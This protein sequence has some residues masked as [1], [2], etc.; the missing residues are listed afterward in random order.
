VL[1]LVATSAAITSLSLVL[2]SDALAGAEEIVAQETAAELDHALSDMVARAR[3]HLASHQLLEQDYRRISYEILQGYSAMEG[4][5]LVQGRFVGHTSPTH[6]SAESTLRPPTD[7]RRTIREILEGTSVKGR[8]G[9]SFRDGND[10]VV[11]RVSTANGIN[12]WVMKRHV[13]FADPG[14]R[15][16]QAFALMLAAIALV[17]VLLVTLSAVR[18]RRGLQAI[19]HGLERMGRDSTYRLP[20]TRGELGPIADSVNRMADSRLRL[21]EELRREDRLRAMGRV[22]AG[23]AH[24][25]KNPLNSIRLCLQMLARARKAPHSDEE[26]IQMALGEVDR[27]NR[28]LDSLLLF[29]E[30]KPANLLPCPVQPVLERVASL[31]QPQAREKG[32]NLR[33]DWPQCELQAWIDPDCL[34]QSLMNLLL[35]AIEATPP[36]GDICLSAQPT[37]GAAVI[38]VADTG[39][40]LSDEQQDH[41]FEAFYTTKD[42]GT[43]LGLA[44]T[45][46]L[47]QRLGGSINYHTGAP[48]A[49]FELR[50]RNA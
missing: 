18:F 26:E 49:V 50:F 40:G 16:R 1:L 8:G 31:V 9:A 21:Q 28:L 38:R 5:F 42:R 6:A 41:L 10:L 7:E 48:G 35:N 3:A 17:F 37:E 19:Q 23:I 39:P 11:V 27:L 47:V 2:V 24:E 45:R 44:V 12:A 32:I 15:R 29:R 43:G 22:V 33:R 46:E 4:G 20:G 36:G 25:I 14:E 13:N 34:Q 30:Q